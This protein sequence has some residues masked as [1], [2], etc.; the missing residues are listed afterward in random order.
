VTADPDPRGL[1]GEAYRVQG[2]GA[3]ECRSI[4]L[5]WVLG[6]PQGADAAALSRALL[7]RP[8]AIPGHPMTT[9]LE[10]ATRSSD[11]PRRRGGR[12][13]LSGAAPR[14]PKQGR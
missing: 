11:P 2:I 10:S 4:F 1:I 6:L 9:V 3:A 13:R 8:E 5:D 7:A 12:S 14:P